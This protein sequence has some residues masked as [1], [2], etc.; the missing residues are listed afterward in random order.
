MDHTEKLAAGVSGGMAAQSQTRNYTASMSMLWA[1]Q[2]H[3]GLEFPMRTPFIV[4]AQFS[5]GP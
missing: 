1:S 4:G 2:T 5:L 3:R